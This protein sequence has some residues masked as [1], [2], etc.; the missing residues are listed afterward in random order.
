[1]KPISPTTHKNKYA[2]FPIRPNFSKDLNFTKL[3]TLQDIAMEPLNRQGSFGKERPKTRQQTYHNVA[4]DRTLMPH[5]TKN[6]ST[7]NKQP[8]VVK[9]MRCERP[10][11]AYGSPIL[12]SVKLDTEKQ[13]EPED[14]GLDLEDEPTASKIQI[15]I[16]QP[17]EPS[18]QVSSRDSSKTPVANYLKKCTSVTYLIGLRNCNALL[19]DETNETAQSPKKNL[20]TP[21]KQEITHNIPHSKKPYALKSNLDKISEIG[22]P[23]PAGKSSPHSQKK[24]ILDTFKKNAFE[25]FLW[26]QKKNGT[27]NSKFCILTHKAFIYYN[28]KGGTKVKGCILY[29]QYR[30]KL[31]HELNVKKFEYF[32]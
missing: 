12:K 17:H 20:S 29:S 4:I 32:L 23:T 14:F 15:L 26:K 27:W 9:V 28:A 30:A 11:P 31:I 24:N 25:G 16:V 8:R 19:T 5:H 13:P 2:T 10:S 3:T 7:F 18:N 22:S 1:M 6:I 21:I